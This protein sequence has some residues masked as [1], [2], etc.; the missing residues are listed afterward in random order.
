MRYWFGPWVWH[1]D[2]M[3]GMWRMPEG[4]MFAIDYRS[5]DGRSRSGGSPIGYGVFATPSHITLGSEYESLGGLD[6]PWGSSPRLRWQSAF[7]LPEAMQANT[8]RDVLWETITVQG[9]PTGEERVKPLLPDHRRRMRVC[10]GGTLVEKRFNPSGPEALV[11]LDLLRRDYL[12]VRQE[13]IDGLLLNRRGDPDRQKH[14]KFLGSLVEKYRLNYRTFQ[15]SSPDERPI[16]P[17]TTF[18]E[19]WDRAD[20]EDMD[21]DLDWTEVSGAWNIHSNSCRYQGGAV[22]GVLRA[23]HSLST[24]D[25]YCQGPVSVLGADAAVGTITRWHAS[26]DTGYEGYPYTGGSDEMVIVSRVAGS[27]TGIASGAITTSLPETYRMESDGSTQTGYQA[28]VQRCQVTDT[29]ITANLQ[30]GV[31]AYENPSGQD[32]KI[33]SIEA[34]DFVAGGLNPL[35]FFADDMRGNMTDMSGGMRG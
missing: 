16:R 15:G 23:E 27:R 3:G 6:D 26:A 9:D 31:M 12:R 7:K 8:L 28:G 35:L 13:S 25:Q 4:S 34:S 22:V 1:A 21:N 18:N 33:D 20:T 11:G 10:M 30:F 5:L 17:E 24:D 14:L 32:P 29:A 19:D 2:V